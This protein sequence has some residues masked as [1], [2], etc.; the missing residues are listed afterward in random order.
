MIDNHSVQGVATILYQLQWYPHS[1]N[2]SGNNYSVLLPFITARL[3]R[4][5]AIY[6]DCVLPIYDS[7]SE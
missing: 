5:H 2:L 6:S 4:R 7:T 3:D 1:C